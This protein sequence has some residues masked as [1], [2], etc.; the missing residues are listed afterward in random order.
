MVWSHAM[1]EASL[2]IWSNITVFIRNQSISQ[3][4]KYDDLN[5]QV[6]MV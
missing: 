3:E 6:Y 5:L 4:M 1:N 2:N